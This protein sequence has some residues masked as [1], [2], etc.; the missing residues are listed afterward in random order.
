MQHMAKYPLQMFSFKTQDQLLMEQRS[1][2]DG[3]KLNKVHDRPLCFMDFRVKDGIRLGKVV[4]ELYCDVAP[5]AVENFL[6]LCTGNC[7]FTYKGCLVYNVINGKYCEMGDLAKN[8]DKNKSSNYTNKFEIENYEL[9]HTKAGKCGQV[10]ISN[11]QLNPFWF[12]TNF[13]NICMLHTSP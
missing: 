1:V 3:L 11:S 5:T 13:E 10:C 4:F 6:I 7:G 9:K 2:S 8:I 12:Y